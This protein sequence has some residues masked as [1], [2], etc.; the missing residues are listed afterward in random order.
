[1][2][3]IHGTCVH[4]ET[5]AVLLRGPPGAGKSDLALRLIDAGGKLVADDQVAVERDG[6]T[7]VARPPAAIAG[8]LEVRGLGPVKLAHRAEATV[9][10]VVDLVE[11]AAVARLP[12]PE[13][14][15]IEGVQVPLLRFNAFECSTAA[16]IALA[17]GPQVLRGLTADEDA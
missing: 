7:L 9:G 16:K 2:T 14:C 17:L 10:L 15:E 8:L 11:T 4:L 1:M 3:L 5:A 6:K 13:A 12:V